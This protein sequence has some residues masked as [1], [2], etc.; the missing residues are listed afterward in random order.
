M[1]GKPPY[2]RYY[3][4]DFIADSAVQA[5][6]CE[7]VGAYWLLL[8][9]AW[10]ETAAGTVPDH[11]ATLARWAKLTV[12]RW[13]RIKDGV[14]AAWTLQDDGRWHQKRM[15][16]EAAD[17]A[18]S[19]AKQSSGG[20]RGADIRWGKIAS[21]GD[22][23]PKGIPNAPLMAP[24]YGSGSGS[25]S[26]SSPE[27]GGAGGGVADPPDGDLTPERIAHEWCH[28]HRGNVASQRNPYGV[29]KEFREWIDRNLTTPEQLFAA[30]RDPTR[31]RTE[32]VFQLKQR[33]IPKEKSGAKRESKRFREPN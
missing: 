1:P 6:T 14:M 23:Q 32:A 9:N 2:F 13:K 16:S 18:E 21:V 7:Q 33:L 15:V 24:A 11:D 5:M 19:L 31:D 30:I 29:A 27:E 25:G 28:E 4:K 20:K 22:G 8:T 12:S 10:F 26:G 17:I 3:G